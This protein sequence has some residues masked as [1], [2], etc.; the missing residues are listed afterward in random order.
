MTPR[1]YMERYLNLSIR[2]KDGSST[3]V[4]VNQY[5]NTSIEKY[6]KDKAAWSAFAAKL[7]RK[8]AGITST[9]HID[10]VDGPQK[11]EPPVSP[12]LITGMQGQGD[13]WMVMASYVFG[14]KGAPEHCQIVLQL[15]DHWG[16]TKGNLQAYADKLGLDCNGFVGNYLWHVRKNAPWTDLGHN[17]NT[18][19]PDAWIPNYIMKNNKPV[20]GRWEDLDPSKTYLMGWANATNGEIRPN[21]QMAH[22]V[23]TEPNQT[24]PLIPIIGDWGLGYEMLSVESW[25]DSPGLRETRYGLVEF[26]ERKKIFKISRNRKPL[27]MWFKIAE[28]P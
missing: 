27:D 23:I 14:G 19:G 9:L 5:R 25:P 12:T 28:A 6:G 16:L 15:A 26:N 18:Y 20:I 10:T 1:G 21:G 22:I 3:P 24:R 13:A 8:G 17:E 4:K 7:G 2:R 11:L